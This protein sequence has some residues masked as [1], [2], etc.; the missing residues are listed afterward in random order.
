MRR[1]HSRLT[2]EAKNRS[3]NVWLLRENTDVVRQI[4]G[5]KII[6]AVY[7]HVVIR[8][9]LERILAREPAFV[10]FDVDVRVR[11]AQ[12]IA[13]RIQLFPADVFGAVQNLPL[14]IAKIDI[15]NRKSKTI[16]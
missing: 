14:Q 13:R 9:N 2:V 12:T 8:D 7:D 3:V 6:R 1:K 10:G 5:W 4:A 15:C 16:A 11:V